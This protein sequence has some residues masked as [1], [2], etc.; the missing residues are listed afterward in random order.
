M[1]IDVFCN[2]RTEFT[3]AMDEATRRASQDGAPPP[4]ELEVWRETTG[5]K[6]GRIYG[7]GLES[8]VIDGRPYYHGLGLQSINC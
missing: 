1:L 6:K 3:Y 5:V 4:S 7:L 8:T 2:W